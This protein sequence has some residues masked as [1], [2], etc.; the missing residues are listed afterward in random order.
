MRRTC[1]P[2]PPRRSACTGLT[3]RSKRP[4]AAQR[5][6]PQ[7]APA[8][9]SSPPEASA[10]RARSADRRDPRSSKTATNCAVG[11]R[12]CRSRTRSQRTTPAQLRPPI[13]GRLNQLEILRKLCFKA[14]RDGAQWR[15][16]RAAEQ[17]TAS[18]ADRQDRSAG[19]TR[20]S[21]FVATQPC[22]VCSEPIGRP[23]SQICR[24]AG[25]VDARSATNSPCHCVVTITTRCIGTA[26]K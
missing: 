8:Q 15:L 10:T 24:T 18:P 19:E 13:K 17:A 3:R 5:L 2:S 6:D 9:A 22:L 23:S 4:Q 20:P 16:T 26:T 12:L 7:T 25:D 1:S 11:A 21:R 14:N